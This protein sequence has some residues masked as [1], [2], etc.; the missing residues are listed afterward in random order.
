MTGSSSSTAAGGGG[1]SGGGGGGKAICRDLYEFLKDAELDHYYTS[2][3]HTLKVTSVNQLKYVEDEDLADIGLTKPEMRRLRKFFLREC[4]QS[5]VGR[6]RKR[7]TARGGG[8]GRGGG[9][10]DDCGASGG[11]GAG[12]GGGVGA[13]GP[14]LLVGALRLPPSTSYLIPPDQI[15]LGKVLGEGGFGRVYQA[16]WSPGGDRGQR[17]QV[18]VKA[19]DKDRLSP[20][21]AADF[22]KEV[23]NMHGIEHRN[24]VRLYGLA[25]GEDKFQMVTELAPLR[26]LLECVREAALRCSFHVGALCSFAQQIAEG[27]SYLE[28]QRLIHRD[29]AARNILVFTKDR[30]KISDFGMSRA[31]QLGKEYYQTNFNVNLKLPI[32]WCAPE[33]INYLRFTSASDVWAYAVTLW[34]MFSYGF[35]PW[36]GLTGQQILETIDEPQLGRLER[37]DACPTAHYALMLKCWDHDSKRRP[38]FAEIAAHLPKIIPEKHVALESSPSPPAVREQLHFAAG[39][40]LFVLD[41]RMGGEPWRGIGLS[42]NSGFFQPH[43]TRPVMHELEAAAAAAAAAA[44]PSKK[45]SR[46]ATL[47]SSYAK[48]FSAKVNLV[49]KA[50]QSSKHHQQHQPRI[51]RDM[52][53]GPQDDFRHTGHVGHDGSVFGDVSFMS[54]SGLPLSPSGPPPPKPTPPPPTT[55]SMMMM[56]ASS[57]PP[58]TKALNLQTAATNSSNNNSTPSPSNMS[59]GSVTSVSTMDTLQHQPGYCKLGSSLSLGVDTCTLASEALAEALEEDEEDEEDGYERSA[60]PGRPSGAAE[61]DLFADF[62]FSDFGGGFGGDTASSG[63]GGGGGGSGSGVGGSGDSS[64]GRDSTDGLGLTG[65]SS[66]MDEIFK[67]WSL[68]GGDSDSGSNTLTLTSCRQAASSHSNGNNNNSTLGAS[69][70]GGYHGNDDTDDT[71]SISAALLSLNLGSGKS[72]VVG[73]AGGGGCDDE[74]PTDERGPSSLLQSAEG[75]NKRNGGSGSITSNSSSSGEQHAQF[76]NLPHHHQQQQQHHQ[77]TASAAHHQSLNRPGSANSSTNSTASNV[78]SLN[79]SPSRQQQQQQQ[80]QQKRSNQSLNSQGSSD[81]GLSKARTLPG[82]ATSA[83]AAAAPASSGSPRRSSRSSFLSF[84][85]GRRSKAAAAAAASADSA[86]GAAGISKPLL[87]S[88]PIGLQSSSN[89][90]ISTVASGVG[91]EPP[92]GVATIGA[93]TGHTTLRALRGNQVFRAPAPTGTAAAG[94]A[95]SASAALKSVNFGDVRT[96]GSVC[97][98]RLSTASTASNSSET[99]ASV[100]TTPAGSAACAAAGAAADGADDSFWGS[101]FNLGDFGLSGSGKTEESGDAIDRPG[102]YSNVPSNSRSSHLYASSSHRRYIMNED[103]DDDEIM[104]M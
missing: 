36:A 94:K 48:E 73:G 17:I 55:T 68:S 33:S 46:R 13:G 50:A 98:Q 102:N 19:M 3:T 38:T 9:G 91:G 80:Q 7:L 45:V 8:A 52:I 62:N 74:T 41:K 2:M 39:D 32:A 51:R 14:D 15:E 76:R 23:T 104:N 31:L 18:A 70:S 35:Q 60:G 95:S 10:E 72:S 37:P 64:G 67:S 88:G 49:K 25:I 75:I 54:A 16:I 59:L 6:L 78:S 84:A 86:A 93:A 21:Q 34:E 71:D 20:G 61:L 40:T 87:I 103:D 90:S 66:L 85:S 65:G 44:S 79:D 30:V 96:A 29:L 89:S 82:E 56:R 11:G 26:S 58:A 100:A 1:S 22:L 42:G 5:A 101:D 57:Q 4:P 81:S 77:L 24:I 92:A 28:N 27:M 99:T 69:G 63:G 97:S 53:S 12:S 47:G 43:L 83:A